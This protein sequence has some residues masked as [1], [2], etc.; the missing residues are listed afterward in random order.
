[1]CPDCAT[2]MPAQSPGSGRSRPEVST[3]W[4]FCS[5]FITSRPSIVSSVR[6]GSSPPDSKSL[7]KVTRVPPRICN[8][9]WAG[10]TTSPTTSMFPC[11]SSESSTMPARRES[12][13]TMSAIMPK[14]DGFMLVMAR[15]E[16]AAGLEITENSVSVMPSKG[17]PASPRF[18]A[19]I[20]AKSSSLAQKSRLSSPVRGAWSLPSGNP[21]SR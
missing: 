1:M 6:C 20:S 17:S 7:P 19:N 3:T 14:A 16:G 15:P 10:T 18:P 5:R 13:N 2:E 11:H 12:S 9:D 4:L 21:A 8:C